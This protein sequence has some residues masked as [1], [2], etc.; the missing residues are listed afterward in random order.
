[1]LAGSETGAST[2][3]NM[4]RNEERKLETAG[5]EGMRSKR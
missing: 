4:K 2:D 1:M 3:E 5:V